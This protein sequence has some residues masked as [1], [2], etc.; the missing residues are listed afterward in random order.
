M[1]ELPEVE[2]T[3]RGVLPH[4]LGRRIL[5]VTLRESRLRWPVPANLDQLLRDQRVEDIGRRG[6]YLLV[7]VA[8]GTLL[9]HLGMSGSL[10]IVEPEGSTLR[11]H[12]HLDIHLEG[13]GVLRYHDPRR[14]GA[15]LW[16]EGDPLQ[17]ALLRDLGPEPLG[18]EFDG[19]YLRARARG[20]RVAIKPF[21]MDARI[22]VGVGNIY[23]NEALH[24]AG[25]RPQWPAGKVSL[26]R[27]RLLADAV[28]SVLG[29]AIAQGG[30]TLRDYVNG[31]GSPGYFSQS[32]CVYGRAGEPCLRCA[33]PIRAV[34]GAARA[35]FYC[36]TCQ[37]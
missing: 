5:A 31:S 28:R 21:L 3:R 26:Q 24:I 27:Y 13:G 37:S 15:F 20:R 14:F 34:R 6:K 2:T 18:E 35:T 1:P 11:K 17:H 7:R 4:L 10:R 19:D 16:L 25:I 33:R 23:A 8:G 29:N 9:V 12:D 32:L 22:V 30:T 36:S